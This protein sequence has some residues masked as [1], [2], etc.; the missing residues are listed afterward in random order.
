MLLAANLSAAS[1]CVTVVPLP[2]KASA[3]ALGTA[4]DFGVSELAITH[5]TGSVSRPDIIERLDFSPLFAWQATDLLD[6]RAAGDRRTIIAAYLG[7]IKDL[8]PAGIALASSRVHH[9]LA[10]G[11]MLAFAG[12][13]ALAQARVASSVPNPS[14][15]KE[16]LL[17][18]AGVPGDWDGIVITG[19]R[20]NAQKIGP[21]CETQ[22]V[23][24][25][26]TPAL[27]AWRL[28][29]IMEVRRVMAAIE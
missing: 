29:R 21:L 27:R 17:P 24:W 4:R 1:F 5:A 7:G 19:I 3:A 13:W 12:I 16:R 22:A 11:L 26:D 23:A 28:K 8:G 6:R 15:A 9:P 2:L 25:D 14:R 20:K 10:Q 18:D